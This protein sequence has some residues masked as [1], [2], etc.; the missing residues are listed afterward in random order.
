MSA[1]IKAVSASGFQSFTLS[2]CAYLAHAVC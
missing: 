1:F 2:N